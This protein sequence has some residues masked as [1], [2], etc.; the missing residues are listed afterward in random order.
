MGLSSPLV[1]RDR[2]C[3][4]GAQLLA[5]ATAGHCALLLIAGEAGIG[6]SRLTRAWTET[7]H[8]MD[9]ALLAGMCQEQD[10]DYPFAPFVDALPQWSHEAGEETV[11]ALLGEQCHVLSKIRP[12]LGLPE[13]GPLPPLSPEQEK[14]RIFEAF[15]TLLTR[16]CMR[17]P[18]RMTARRSKSCAWT[19][20]RK[21]PRQ[22]YSP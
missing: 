3:A 21:S 10:R 22:T 14:R 13:A 2:E 11:R 17:R 8:Q 15:V 5:E 6:K 12:E 16:L 4:L 20:W 1:G 18:P 19:A 7:A 9:F